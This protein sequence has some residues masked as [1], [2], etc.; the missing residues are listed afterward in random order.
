[1]TQHGQ[2]WRRRAGE[3]RR[4]RGNAGDHCQIGARKQVRF[5]HSSRRMVIASTQR[6]NGRTPMLGS[7]SSVVAAPQTIAVSGQSPHNFRK[8]G[9]TTRMRSGNRLILLAP[10]AGLE[11][12][13]LRLTESR[14]AIT[15]LRHRGIHGATIRYWRGFL[16]IVLFQVPSRRVTKLWVVS[17]RV[18]TKVPT[19]LGRRFLTSCPSGRSSRPLGA[20][21]PGTM[22]REIE[23]Q[24][25]YGRR[26]AWRF[27]RIIL[28]SVN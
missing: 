21:T 16:R 2:R 14:E 15:R 24:I 7:C 25:S 27:I 23:Y 22:I 5:L 20:V 13:T 12:A 9:E 28:R 19:V 8:R 1:V 18:P 17:L 4:G 10:Q 26:V 3:N 6:R 11:P